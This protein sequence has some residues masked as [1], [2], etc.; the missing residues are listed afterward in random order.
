MWLSSPCW[1][2]LIRCGTYTYISTWRYIHGPFQ[3]VLRL[4]RAIVRLFC[5]RALCAVSPP[6][7]RP[8]LSGTCQSPEAP[9]HSREGHGERA[10]PL[11]PPSLAPPHMCVQSQLLSR[12]YPEF[13]ST[14]APTTR[15]TSSPPVSC[16]AQ[17]PN[18][19]NV[20][21]APPPS[22]PQGAVPRPRPPPPPLANPSSLLSSTGVNSP[23]TR[24]APRFRPSWTSRA[25]APS[26]RRETTRT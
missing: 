6:A 16:L 3:R 18:A 12:A 23:S 24:L 19:A 5:S 15:T 11:V 13:P 26:S 8:W 7:S 10:R 20:P 1:R 14:H 25:S 17:S 4:L 21:L 9:V 2:L 22:F